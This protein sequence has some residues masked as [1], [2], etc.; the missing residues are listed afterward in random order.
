MPNGNIKLEGIIKEGFLVA[1]SSASNIENTPYA[2]VNY[3]MNV[4]RQLHKNLLNENEILKVD[5]VQQVGEL[6]G[7]EVWRK[8][9]HDVRKAYY[10]GASAEEIASDDKYFFD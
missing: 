3:A 2:A 9:Y 8:Y 7:K 4:A 1:L 10:R 6:R 5:I